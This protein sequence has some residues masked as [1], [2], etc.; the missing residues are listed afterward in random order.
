MRGAGQTR[1]EPVR[2][3][4]LADRRLSAP[5]REAVDTPVAHGITVGADT[6]SAGSPAPVVAAAIA[7]FQVVR[8]APFV[9]LF[10]RDAKWEQPH[11]SW[12]MVGVV[13]PALQA[14]AV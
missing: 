11:N 4:L 6:F 8:S 1:E 3:Q 10:G 9:M 12:E 2:R 7:R 14:A 5:G 13:V